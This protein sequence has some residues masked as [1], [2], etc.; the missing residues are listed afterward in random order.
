MRV[1]QSGCCSVYVPTEPSA[2]VPLNVPDAGVSA[3]VRLWRQQPSVL[4]LGAVYPGAILADARLLA[5]GQVALVVGLP[6]TPGVNQTTAMHE[7]WLLDPSTGRLA[8][9]TGGKGIS[10][11]TAF[12]NL[13]ATSGRSH[14]RPDHFRA[15]AS[16]G[17]VPVR[18]T[19][20]AS[21]R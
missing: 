1:A 8:R 13:N 20:R 14:P 2:G 18:G 19:R 21:F 10:K 4:R 7:V 15:L 6:I 16:H 11:G 17:Q 5:D 3:V 9:V 12:L